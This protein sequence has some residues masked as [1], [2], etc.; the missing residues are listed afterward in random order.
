MWGAYTNYWRTRGVFNLTVN[1]PAPYYN[2]SSR[3]PQLRTRTWTLGQMVQ[4][5]QYML[6]EAANGI[7]GAGMSGQVTVQSILNAIQVARDRFVL[8]VRF[9]TGFGVVQ[10]SPAPTNG[11][12]SFTQTSIYVHRVMWQDTFSG[13]WTNLWREDAWSVDKNNPQWT[14]QPSSPLQF[15]EAENSPL[16]LQ[17]SPIPLNEGQLEVLTCDSLQLNQALSSQTF[18]LPDEWIHAVK[19]GALSYILSSESQIFDP[20]RSQYAD[21]R[22]KQAVDLANSARSIIR[23][24]C[25]NYPLPIDSLAAIDASNPY[26]R[27][28]IGI[29]QVAGV[30]YDIVAFSPGLAD[31]PYGIAA[32]VVQSAPLPT[33]SAGPTNYLQVGGEDLDTIA[34]ETVHLLTFKCGGN[35][36][37]ST[38]GGHDDFMKSVAGRN[39]INA[40]KIRYL[41][42]LLAQPQKEWAERPDRLAVT[43][44]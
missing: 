26:W 5:I 15:S 30:L 12:V 3:L 19:Y 27:N 23:L 44:A 8:D 18:G 32:D 2:L 37:K 40:A 20:L 36:F 29:P 35:D 21:F 41:K 9:P 22:Y 13:V 28:Q 31:Q 6:L 4:E 38:W 33:L 39:A 16:Q 43:N 17:I 25:N 1:K 7:S 42:P 14:I 34:K 24:M 11:M 10:V